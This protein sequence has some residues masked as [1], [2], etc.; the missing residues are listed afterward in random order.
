[1]IS[2]GGAR[3]GP[4]LAGDWPYGIR[5]EHLGVR[6]VCV[7]FQPDRA[8]A[9]EAGVRDAFRAALPDAEVVAGEDDG[10][11]ENI[12]FDV[13]APEVALSRIQAVFDLPSVG[14]AAR[15]SCIVMCQGERGWDDCLLLHHYDPAEKVDVPAVRRE[16]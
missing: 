4:G 12:M 10:R 16:E 14:P 5:Q 11:Y 15:A 3:L 7:Q 9:D 2:V 8:I 1:M 13:A 6:R